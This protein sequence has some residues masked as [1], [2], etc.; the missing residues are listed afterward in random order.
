LAC[1]EMSK[2]AINAEK[3]ADG[4]VLASGDVGYVAIR[5]LTSPL[6]QHADSL[7]YQRSAEMLDRMRTGVT[8]DVDAADGWSVT[9]PPAAGLQDQ[10]FVRARFRGMR[11]CLVISRFCNK[12]FNQPWMKSGP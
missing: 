10:V 3:L 8:D 5:D 4:S 7:I 2:F 11:S 6:V 1:I 9:V 12:G